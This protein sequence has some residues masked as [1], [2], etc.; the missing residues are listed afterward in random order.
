M[1]G[2]A[3]PPFQVV[4]NHCQNHPLGHS[5]DHPLDHLFC[6]LAFDVD[7]NCTVVSSN[8]TDGLLDLVIC[9]ALGRNHTRLSLFQL[10]VKQALFSLVVTF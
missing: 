5:F 2:V 8:K 1:E 10:S 6:H 3:K 7:I 9:A 4:P